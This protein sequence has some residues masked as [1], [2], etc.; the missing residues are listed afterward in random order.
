MRRRTF[1]FVGTLVL[2]ALGSVCQAEPQRWLPVGKD[3]WTVFTPSA[4]TRLIYVSSSA[5]DD[6]TGATYAPGAAAVGGEPFQ[7]SGPIHAFKTIAAAQKL[8][9]DGFPDWVLL[10]RGDSWHEAPHMLSGR[11]VSEPSL[12]GAYGEGPRPLLL[13]AGIRLP[14]RGFR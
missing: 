7:P 12:V 10:K 2:L 4:D 9:R 1:C 13:N 11:S 8:A 3:G 5:G 6:A 14:D